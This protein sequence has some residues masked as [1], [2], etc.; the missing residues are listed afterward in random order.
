MKRA[1]KYLL[2]ILLLTACSS[3]K[4]CATFGCETEK[5]KKNSKKKKHKKPTLGLFPKKILK[6]SKN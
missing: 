2:L 3:N 5:Q 1:F 6:A 4:Q